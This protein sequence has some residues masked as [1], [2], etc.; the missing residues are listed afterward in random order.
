MHDPKAQTSTTLRDF[1]E[2]RSEKNCSEFP[3]QPPLQKKRAQIGKI[4]QKQ[5]KILKIDSFLGG[6]IVRD[7][8]LSGITSTFKRA[9]G[10]DTSGH[11][12]GVGPV[13]GLNLQH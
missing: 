11:R 7:L 6:M 10:Y 4:V 3:N 1:R 12:R 13:G 2:L 8:V 9:R 5:Q